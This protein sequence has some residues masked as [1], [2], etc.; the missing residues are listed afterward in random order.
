MMAHSILSSSHYDDGRS[1]RHPFWSKDIVMLFMLVSRTKPGTK[2]QQIID[3]LTKGL[4]PET[5]D[6]V[7]HG[8]LSQ[9]YYRVGEDAGF[10]A[11]LSAPSL[12]E[13]KDLVERGVGATDVFELDVYPVNQFPHFD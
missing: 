1:C 13:A 6:L 5:W 11:L 9:V 7:R 3:R 10:F 2:R 8:V 12:E 4:H